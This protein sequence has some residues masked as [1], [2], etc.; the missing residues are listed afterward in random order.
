MT[1]RLKLRATVRVTDIRNCA[2]F[3]CMR[4]AGWVWVGG[5]TPILGAGCTN[6]L[7]AQ[8]QR[9]SGFLEFEKM[10]YA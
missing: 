5:H 4:D 9:W 1:V 10:L 2:T 7:I 8:G 6:E 3:D